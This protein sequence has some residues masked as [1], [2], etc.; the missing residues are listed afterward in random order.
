[1]FAMQT[2]RK[3]LVRALSEIDGLLIEAGT[4]VEKMAG[5]ERDRALDILIEF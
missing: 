4:I 5:A 2:Y 3:Q 1:V